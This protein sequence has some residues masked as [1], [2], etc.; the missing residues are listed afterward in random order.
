M[1]FYADPIMSEISQECKRKIQ[2]SV[3]YNSIANKQMNILKGI[4]KK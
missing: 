4:L 1:A 2:N 3:G